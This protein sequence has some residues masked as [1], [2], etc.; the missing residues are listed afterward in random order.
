MILR[1]FIFM[2]IAFPFSLQAGSAPGELLI[3]K[4][5]SELSSRWKE[6]NKKSYASVKGKCWKGSKRREIQG[7]L[8]SLSYELS[9][10]NWLTAQSVPN[11]VSRYRTIYDSSRDG[12]QLRMFNNGYRLVETINSGSLWTS[13]IYQNSKGHTTNLRVLTPNSLETYRVLL[14]GELVEFVT[15]ALKD[16]DSHRPIPTRSLG[17]FIYSMLPHMGNV[18]AAE[19]VASSISAW[20]RSIEDKNPRLESRWLSRVSDQVSQLNLDQVTMLRQKLDTHTQKKLANAARSAIKKIGNRELSARSKIAKL[21][22]YQSLLVADGE[23]DIGRYNDLT[24]SV[25]DDPD[26][27]LSVLE[28]TE[29]L[30][31]AK[32]MSQGGMQEGS[33]NILRNLLT[34]EV[35]TADTGLN[36][37]RPISRENSIITP[38]PIWL[39]LV[40]AQ[41][42]LMAFM[43]AHDNQLTAEKYKTTRMFSRNQYVSG[44]AEEGFWLNFE[45]V[46][47]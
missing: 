6:Q 45:N 13:L 8:I 46:V 37:M 32:T 33:A 19:I 36:L 31:I 23:M 3:K 29:L 10:V 18:S 47:N 7:S 12:L 15:R 25:S 5:E 4:L 28:T 38:Y 44:I 9:L 11:E 26:I 42:E 27:R 14:R 22:R 30:V 2:L 34:W 21:W 43:K 1:F 16:C 17:L 35:G 40:P 41:Y 24:K 39:P 20:D